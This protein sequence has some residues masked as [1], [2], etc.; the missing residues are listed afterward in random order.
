MSQ[1]TITEFTAPAAACGGWALDA[2]RWS[3]RAAPPKAAAGVGDRSDEPA[4]DAGL[5]LAPDADAKPAL[6]RRRR[7]AVAVAAALLIVGAMD[8]ATTELALSTGAAREANP[9]VRAIQD[10][11]GSFWI[12]PK[13]AVHALLAA[14][15][16]RFPMP[17]TLIVMGALALVVFYVSVNNLEIYLSIVLKT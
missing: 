11:I 4:A 10:V 8:A 16:M 13:M 9:I 3:R 6:P 1:L 7:L 12:L 14:V 17:I 5:L 15:V 2:K